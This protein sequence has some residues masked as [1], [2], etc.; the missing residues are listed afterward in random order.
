MGESIP[1]LNRD[2]LLKEKELTEEQ[3]ETLLILDVSSGTSWVSVLENIRLGAWLR[4]IVT[5]EYN[6]YLAPGSRDH[7]QI[8]E[9]NGIDPKNCVITNGGLREDDNNPDVVIFSY[10]A[11]Q[12]TLIHKAVEDKILDALKA[13]GINFKFKKTS[14]IND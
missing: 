11:S 14:F 3:L 12:R 7:V 5:E 1:K 10:Q 2:K 6:I 4:F 8:M 9:E 13:R